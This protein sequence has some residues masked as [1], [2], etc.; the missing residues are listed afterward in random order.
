MEVYNGV[1]AFVFPGTRA[2]RDADSWSW[3]NSCLPVGSGELLPCFAF[4]LKLALSQPISF[5]A[6]TFSPGHCEGLSC[7]LRLNHNTNTLIDVFF[8]FSSYM[9]QEDEVHLIV[10]RFLSMKKI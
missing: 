8:L 4:S 7:Q 9:G 3:L 2:T 5:L 10:L 6:S 1:I